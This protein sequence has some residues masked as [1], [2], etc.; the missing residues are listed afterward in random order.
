MRV[1]QVAPPW[2][3][4][5]PWRY[6]GIELVIG[7]LCDGMV[8]AGH[9]VTLLASGGS[10]T[11][12]QLHTVYDDPPS[13]DLGDAVTELLH[14]IEAD[15]LGPFDVVHDHTLLGTVRHAARGTWPLVH[16]LHGPWTAR[17]RAL[18][19]RLA[20]DVALV[21]ISHDQAARAGGIPLHGVVHN[22]LDLD[23]YPITLD[24]TEDLA[25]VGRASPEK[26]PVAAIEVARRT[27]RRLVMAIKLNEPHEHAYFREVVAPR[28]GDADVEVVREATHEQKT[29][30]LSRAAVV[31]APV[32]WDEPF[33]LVLAEAGACG[34]PIVAFGRGAAPEVIRDGV[35]GIVVDPA[36]GIS[37]LCEAVEAASTIDGA[38]CRRHVAEHFSSERMVDGYL[39]VYDDLRR[40]RFMRARPAALAPPYVPPAHRPVATL[41]SVSPTS[42]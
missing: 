3:E 18:Y 1:L 40:P 14:V 24:H 29:A 10:A 28:L 25:F 4:V 21:A 16:T 36:A 15:D 7:T 17:S 11:T 12:A 2:F 31:V 37:G 13:A 8:A 42:R 27:G 5:P 33:G 20:E 26:G 32:A 9:E 38:D 22:G 34:T 39:Q 6:G 19:G 23:R 30:I 35:S 41:P